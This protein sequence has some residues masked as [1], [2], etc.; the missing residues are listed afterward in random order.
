MEGTVGRDCK[1]KC[2][3]PPPRVLKKLGDDKREESC[4]EHTLL[5]FE[6]FGRNQATLFAGRRVVPSWPVPV[7]TAHVNSKLCVTKFLP[8]L[9]TV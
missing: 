4:G 7:P 1:V 5:Q 2:S 3:E 9:F 8:L 6:A